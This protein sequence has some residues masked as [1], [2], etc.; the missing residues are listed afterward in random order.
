MRSAAAGV[1]QPRS[2]CSARSPAATASAAP[3]CS[4]SAELGDERRGQAAER[5]D[6]R[7]VRG[8]EAARVLPRAARRAGC[9]RRSRTWARRGSPRARRRWRRRARSGSTS[10][11]SRV[12]LREAGMEPFEIMIS[13]SQERM[14]CV[15]EPE[16]LDEVL[17]RL[18]ALGGARHAD[19]RGHRHAPA[20]RASRATS[21]SATCRSTALVDDCPL[22]DLEPESA[23]RAGL[24][25]RRRGARR[26]RRAAGHAARAAALA[27]HRQQALGVRAVRLDRRLAHRAPPRGGRRRGA[28]SS[29][30]TAARARS[31]CRSTATA[32]AWPATRTRARSRRCSSAPPTSPASAP[33][34]SA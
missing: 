25:R 8:V 19:R 33:S 9:S 20:A 12:P 15:V 10:T 1:G 11:S 13:E 27:E 30:R 16:R 22:Y 4:P 34:R 29:R 24:R 3:R 28:R 7:P 21:W 18:R 14:L 32:G 31:P 26:R 2:C 23:G 6:R 17:A 5:P